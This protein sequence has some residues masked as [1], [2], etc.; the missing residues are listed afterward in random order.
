MKIK[1]QERI[2]GVF[3]AM[4][5]G[6]LLLSEYILPQL[7]MQTENEHDLELLAEIAMGSYLM[8]HPAVQDYM[9]TKH[10]IVKYNDRRISFF[11]FAK[12]ENN[13]YGFLMDD[14]YDV[15]RFRILDKEYLKK[16]STKTLSYTDRTVGE[17]ALQFSIPPVELIP[18]IYRGDTPYTC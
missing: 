15:A 10:Y 1:K 5:D 18:S 16:N 13:V 2:N 7:R 6:N 11:A 12:K 9:V 14:V 8:Y 4:V 17:I 3:N